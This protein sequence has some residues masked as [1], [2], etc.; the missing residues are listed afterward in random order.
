MTIFHDEV[1]IED[2]EYDE[3]EEMYYYPCPCGD[4]FQI[5]KVRISKTLCVQFSKKTSSINTFRIFFS[6]RTDG[7]RGSG[8]MSQLFPCC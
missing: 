6:G 2:F 8:Y 7:W 4:Q 5:S 1:E 3:D